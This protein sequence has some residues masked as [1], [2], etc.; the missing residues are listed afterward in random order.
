MIEIKIEDI[1]R[2]NGRTGFEHGKKRA[3]CPIQWLDGFAIRDP[4]LHLAFLGDYTD[5]GQYG[6][7]VVYTLLRLL[8]ANPDLAG[9][10]F[11]RLQKDRNAVFTGVV[12]AGERFLSL[13]HI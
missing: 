7:E 13:I 5:R 4:D 9:H 6:V 8:A 10:I 2:G 1:R 11:L 12:D 3:A